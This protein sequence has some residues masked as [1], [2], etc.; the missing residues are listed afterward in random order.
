MISIKERIYSKAF[1]DGVNYTIQKM[2]GEEEEKE[3]KNRGLGKAIGIGSG[4][5]LASHALQVPIEGVAE[6]S[7]RTLKKLADKETLK[8]IAKDRFATRGGIAAL[9]SKVA[10]GAGIAA[11]GY[12]IGKNNKKEKKD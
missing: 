10:A 7:R 1:E 12:K 11:A 8:A 3:R 9:A 2:F 4:I 5:G 6:D